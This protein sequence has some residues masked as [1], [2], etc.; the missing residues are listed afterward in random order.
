M[1]QKK[2]HLLRE[3][4][5]VFKKKYGKMTV[6]AWL[7]SELEQTRPAVMLLGGILMMGGGI[8]VRWF[9]G[10]PYARMHELGIGEMIPPVWL[11]TLLWTLAFF[12]VGCAAGYVL[13]F[14]IRGCEGEK[15]KGCMLFVLVAVLELCW[16]PTLF[17][18][19]LL[20]LSVLESIAILCFAVGATVSF[21]RVSKFAGFLLLLHDVWLCY[22]LILNFS[23]F[24]TV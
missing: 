4:L 6:N 17:G 21:Y 12:I 8:L 14:R 19:G 7:L 2:Q 23:V 1:S 15:Y 11:M 20:F 18:A 13:G 5:F 16:Y 9:T 24:F 10:S 3:V 22:L